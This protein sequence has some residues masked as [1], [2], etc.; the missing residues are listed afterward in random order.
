MITCFLVFV[1][2]RK[3]D[4]WKTFEALMRDRSE[5]LDFTERW[6]ELRD[7]QSCFKRLVSRGARM[8]AESKVLFL[9]LRHEL[10]HEKVRPERHPETE[11]PIPAGHPYVLQL[12]RSIAS[13]EVGLSVRQGMIHLSTDFC[14]PAFLS[15][16]FYIY[17][18]H[19][20]HGA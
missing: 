10:I 11:K 6:V 9:G 15:I 20:V 4:E 17:Q 14:K 8:D 13:D 1:A 5:A 19:S 16:P 7:E 12:M 18:V 2:E 3:M